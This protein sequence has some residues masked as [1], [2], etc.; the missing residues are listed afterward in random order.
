VWTE[1]S[2]PHRAKWSAKAVAH[3]SSDMSTPADENAVA[4]VGTKPHG[5]YIYPSQRSAILGE[6]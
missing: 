6:E 5:I 1:A 2:P 4:N 3:A